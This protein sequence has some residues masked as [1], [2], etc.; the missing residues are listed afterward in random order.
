MRQLF[1]CSDF[2]ENL[3]KNGSIQFEPV[4]EISN[5]MSASIAKKQISVIKIVKRL[6]DE[7]MV[8]S[9]RKT[10]EDS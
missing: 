8:R 1:V 4:N 3:S 6:D 7:L 5:V 2:K 10:F 9:T